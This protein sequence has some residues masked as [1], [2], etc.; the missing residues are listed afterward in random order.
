[1][2]KSKYYYIHYFFCSLYCAI[3]RYTPIVWPARLTHPGVGN[4]ISS[5]VRSDI[6]YESYILGSDH[7]LSDMI[8][9]SICI[10]LWWTDL[11]QDVAK[12]MWYNLT[13]IPVSD[14]PSCQTWYR[15]DNS[16]VCKGVANYSQVGQEPIRERSVWLQYYTV[17]TRKLNLQPVGV[18]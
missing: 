18:V 16:W 11:Y 2:H 7:S 17:V 12:N 14:W 6:R 9:F 10:I 15:P 5:V 4:W 1:M 8:Q 13:I 3:W